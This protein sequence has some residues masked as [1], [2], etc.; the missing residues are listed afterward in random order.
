MKDIKGLIMLPGPP[1]R[2]Q[3]AQCWGDCALFIGVSGSLSHLPHSSLCLLGASRL[4]I[5]TQTSGRHLSLLPK[6]H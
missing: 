6:Y 5:S 2:S 3:L 1:V 4:Q